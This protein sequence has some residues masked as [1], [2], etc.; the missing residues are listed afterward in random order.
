M[1]IQIPCSAHLRNFEFVCR[2]LPRRQSEEQD[3]DAQQD[4][5]AR[6]F[7][8]RFYHLG[9]SPYKRGGHWRNLLNQRM[10]W[11]SQQNPKLHML[12][13]V[14]NMEVWGKCELQCSRLGLHTS[15][16]TSILSPCVPEVQ[17]SCLHLDTGMMH[18]ESGSSLSASM[19]A[20]AWLCSTPLQDWPLGWHTRFRWAVLSSRNKR[21]QFTR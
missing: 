5:Q 11:L 2:C 18:S 7:V 6:R 1:S 21:I 17:T 9:W 13:R 12:I 10:S 19:A 3:S 16:Q 8:P 20:C 14:L 4:Y 15:L